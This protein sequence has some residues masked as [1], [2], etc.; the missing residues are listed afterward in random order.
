MTN[1]FKELFA[2]SH[3]YNQQLAKIFIE[4]ADKTSEKPLIW[5]NH[6]LNAHLIWNSRIMGENISVKPWDMHAVDE[7]KEMDKANYSNSLLILDSIEMYRPIEYGNSKGQRFSNTVRDILFHI[8]NHSTYHRGQIAADF[9]Q[10]GIEP[11]VTDY[12]FYKR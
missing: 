3:H 1:F 11:L 12:I 9:R 5:F 4:K 7:L 10:Q 6:I 2:Y 8:I